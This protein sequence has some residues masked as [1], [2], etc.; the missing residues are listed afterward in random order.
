MTLGVDTILV[1]ALAPVLHYVRWSA[2]ERRAFLPD[3][4]R[5]LAARVSPTRE[6]CPDCKCVIVHERGEWALDPDRRYRPDLTPGL[7]CFRTRE[8]TR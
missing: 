5:A 3:G 1:P 6:R 2:A 4:K 7:C 8:E